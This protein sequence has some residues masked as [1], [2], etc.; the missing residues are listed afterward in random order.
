MYCTYKQLYSRFWLGTAHAPNGTKIDCKAFLLNHEE[1][2][3][4]H[5]LSSSAKH[6]TYLP[7]LRQNL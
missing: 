1:G 2:T 3:G 7:F 6:S 5:M 4:W